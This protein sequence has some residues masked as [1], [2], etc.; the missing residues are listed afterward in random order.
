MPTMRDDL[1]RVTY[2]RTGTITQVLL[3]GV[4]IGRIDRET[5]SNSSPRGG[6]Y[7]DFH[8][9][10]SINPTTGERTKGRKCYT[11]REA[12]EDLLR[13][14]RAAEVIERECP[15]ECGETFEGKRHDLAGEIAVHQLECDTKV[16]AELA[17]VAQAQA[18][19]AAV[20]LLG[21]TIAD[22]IAE[23]RAVT[24]DVGQLRTY[25]TKGGTYIIASRAH[26]NDDNRPHDLAAITR[27]GQVVQLKLTAAPDFLEAVAALADAS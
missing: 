17:L 15:N 20:S 13:D 4:K 1:T 2:Q 10:T 7:R 24:P 26:W 14:W 25:I 6:A 3:D 19:E 12:V 9:P 5:G 11:R 16:A 18:V 27:F 8:T 22:A 21:E 23:R